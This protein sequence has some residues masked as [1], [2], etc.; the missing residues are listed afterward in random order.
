M[1]AASPRLVTPSLPRMLDTC[2]LAVFAEMNSSLAISRLLCPAASEPEHLVLPG[3]E[4]QRGIGPRRAAGPGHRGLVPG[5]VP[6]GERDPGPPG[7]QGDAVAQRPGAQLPG[8]RPGP[9]QP[10]PGR[11]AVAGAQRRLGRPE[12]GRGQRMGLGHGLP[13]L[14]RI[15]PGGPGVSR[16]A[17]VGHHLGGEGQLVSLL[18]QSFRGQLAGRGAQLV[19]QRGRPG[20]QRPVAGHGPGCARPGPGDQQRPRV[21]GAAQYVK[22]PERRPPPGPGRLRAVPGPAAAR[23]PGAPGA[24]GARP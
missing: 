3:R 10:G 11:V 22:A 2:T 12:Q 24:A 14:R 4:A 18:R 15:I 1:A 9:A 7:D 21:A 5:P 16:C 6:A 23:C 8:Q 13:G 19:A 17:A 20:Q